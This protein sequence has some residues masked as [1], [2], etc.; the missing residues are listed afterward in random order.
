MT[1]LSRGEAA[2]W[3]ESHL[4]Q[5]CTSFASRIV[6]ARQFSSV[7]RNPMPVSRAAALVVIFVI[8]VS[9]VFLAARVPQNASTQEMDPSIKPGDDFYRYANGGWIKT[10]AIPPGQ[11]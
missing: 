1:A 3:A 7:E 9:G 4:F 2:V 5:A 10:A 11:A 8:F 6:L